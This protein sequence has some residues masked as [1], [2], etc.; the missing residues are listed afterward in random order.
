MRT[1]CLVL[2]NEPKP[3]CHYQWCYLLV[4][5]LFD[6]YLDGIGSRKL[7]YWLS[8]KLNRPISLVTIKS[9]LS[10]EHYIG[11]ATNSYGTS[12]NTY[13]ALISDT[14][15]RAV[16]NDGKMLVAQLKRSHERVTRCFKNWNAQSVITDWGGNVVH[17]RGRTYVYYCCS[18]G[19]NIADK[20]RRHNYRVKAQTTRQAVIK[21]VRSLASSPNLVDNI[22]RELVAR[23]ATLPARASTPQLLTES[24]LYECLKMRSLIKLV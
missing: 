16:Q 18:M 13:P 10:N 19:Y 2:P 22:S 17:S 1:S 20:T 5:E 3:A 23:L 4:I 8:D 11:V 15:F 9:M 6:K 14:I 21:I 24:R 7:A 12:T